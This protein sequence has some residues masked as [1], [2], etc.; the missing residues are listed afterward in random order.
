MTGEPT[1]TPA[2]VLELQGFGVGFAQKVVLAEV[3]LVVP[4]R[5]ILTLLGPSATGKSTLLRTLAGHN[6]AN[7]S[8]RTWGTANYLGRPLGEGERPALVGQSARLMMASVV[9]NVVH[10]HPERRCLSPMEQRDLAAR[11]LIAAGL[12]EL[13][14]Q[15]DEPVVNLGLALQ[16]HIAIVREVAAN[17]PLLCLDEPTTNLDDADAA[18][19][20]E[21]LLREADE[22]ALLVALHNQQ[23]AR[24]L[25]GSLV[26]LAG[27]RIQEQAAAQDFFDVPRTRA[28]RE[29][30]RGGGCSLPSPDAR[31]EDLDEDMA[32][33]PPLPAEART[34]VSD[35][36]GPRG[37][38]WLKQ[39]RLAG[40]PMPGVVQDL[41][42]DLTALRRV[43]VTWLITLTERAMD[44]EQLA[45]YDLSCAWYPIDDAEAP[46]IIQGI[47]IC[48]QI[49]RL[50]AEGEVVAVHCRAGLGRT[51]TVLAAYLIWEGSKAL[52][53]LEAV[54][55]VE[56]RWVQSE[57]QIL[58][59]EKFAVTV[60]NLAKRPSAKWADGL[61]MPCPKAAASA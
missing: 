59:L 9:E 21:H 60:A 7:P 57:S 50:L 19:L 38:L 4:E 20:L 48:T 8:H 10:G 28:G 16:R 40:T 5:G 58:F 49:E 56:P 36:F 39:G 3:D 51:G 29:F 46:G 52:D 2:P 55:R 53:A 25:G 18:R 27:G 45:A 1:E 44:V 33:P 43:G 37:F 41:D 42:Y 54:R 30:V 23:H 24:Q 6:S 22:R 17:P 26:L 12:E 35:V 15:L 61:A 11:L 47:S 13:A 14:D 32:P 34:F 31:P